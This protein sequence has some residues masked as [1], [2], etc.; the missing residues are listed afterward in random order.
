MIF[1]QFFPSLKLLMRRMWGLVWRA[2][3]VLVVLS[4][5]LPAHGQANQLWPEVSTYVKLNDNV[6]FYFLSTTVKEDRES[7]EWEFGPNLDLFFKPLKKKPKWVVFPQDESKSRSVMVRIGYRY[8]SPVTG[9]DPG[10]H[11]GVLEVTP[12]YPMPHGVLLSDRDRIDFRLIGGVYSWR[13]RNRL[14]LEKV[15]S[16]G[17]F[18]AVPYVRGEVYYDSRFDKWSRTALTAGSAFPTTKHI[19]L[20]SYYEHQN[21][22]SSNPNRQVNALGVV[23]NLYFSPWASGKKR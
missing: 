20:E 10:E 2:G 6:R 7:T 19:E 11:R 22:T 17:R 13:Y 16:R 4:F 3:A 15:F 12:R 14:T 5:A 21:D 1:L 8:I 23:V 9:S 18:T